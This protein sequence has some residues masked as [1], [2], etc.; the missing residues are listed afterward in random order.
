MECGSKW[1]RKLILSMKVCYRIAVFKSRM[2]NKKQFPS[3][4]LDG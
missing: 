2:V 3:L 4:S 1:W